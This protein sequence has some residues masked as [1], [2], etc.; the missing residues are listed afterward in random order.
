[1]VSRLAVRADGVGLARVSAAGQRCCTLVRR[2]LACG[3]LVGCVLA[4]G[5]L[6]CGSPRSTRFDDA[7][8]FRVGLDPRT[9]ADAIEAR[10]TARG[11]VRVARVDSDAAVGLA[12]RDDEGRTVLRIV[13]TRGLALA[14]DAP[15]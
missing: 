15:T 14:V 12:M 1:R 11:L 3:A 8:H 4:S 2:W 9:E 6:A 5:S 13:T 10:L 7:R